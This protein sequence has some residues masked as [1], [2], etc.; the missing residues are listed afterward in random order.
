LLNFYIKSKDPRSH[1]QLCELISLTGM[2]ILEDY[3]GD[4]VC[5]SYYGMFHVR[6][7]EEDFELVSEFPDIIIEIPPNKILR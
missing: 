6:G 5:E 3:F 2:E 7:S 1:I 4:S